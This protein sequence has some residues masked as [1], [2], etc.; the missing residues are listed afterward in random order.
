[1]VETTMF[2]QNFFCTLVSL[3]VLFRVQSKPTKNQT[4]TGLS[5][6][7]LAK[8]VTVGID[9]EIMTDGSNYDQSRMARS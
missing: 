8:F 1:M 4:S 2:S 7:L 3:E 6:I 9:W 5:N